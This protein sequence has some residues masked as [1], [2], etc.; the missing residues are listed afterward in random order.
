MIQ[1]LGVEAKYGH[2]KAI[3]GDILVPHSFPLRNT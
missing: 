2:Y 3:G 1:F